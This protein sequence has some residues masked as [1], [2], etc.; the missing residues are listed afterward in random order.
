VVQKKASIMPL[1]LQLAMARP[2]W[3]HTGKNLESLV[4]KAI[5]EFDLLATTGEQKV[6][7][8]L[9]GGKDSLALLFLLHAISA[10]GIAK[11]D[12]LAIHVHGPY[13]CGAGV[14]LNYL[15]AVCNALQV[16]LIIKESNQT[17]DEL[18]CYSCSRLR[19]KL[20]FDCAKEHGI[21]N[22]AFGH[23]RDDNIQTL[24]MNVLHKATPAGMLAKVPMHRYGV[25]IIRPLIYCSEQ[26]IIHFAGQYG[27][28]RI[29]CQ[30]PVGQTSKRKVVEDAIQRLE[31][32][33]P[34][35]RE[36]LSKVSIK[37]GSQSALNLPDSFN[38]NDS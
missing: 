13:S 10:R 32:D 3:T 11:L 22:V 5:Y 6:A 37:W 28:R 7:I 21:M 35:I 12:L 23:H 19:R 38:E 20:L 26:S 14:S 27:F 33:F 1:N 34:S 9:S 17:L 36:N 8:A 16:R 29:T 4:R 2:P 24:L 18:E 30:C 25:T 31:K 15:Q